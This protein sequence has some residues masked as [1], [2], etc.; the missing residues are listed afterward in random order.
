MI[1]PN[2]HI[3]MKLI[4]HEM[5]KYF[6]SFFA[7]IDF[8]V[9][10]PCC[11]LLIGRADARYYVLEEIYE[12]E[13]TVEALAH[14]IKEIENKWQVGNIRRWVAGWGDSV[15]WAMELQKYGIS[16]QMVEEKD[17]TL[18]IQTVQYLLTNN[19]YDGD[20]QLKVSPSCG[21][22]IR[23]FG[24]YQWK[25][26]SDGK[27]RPGDKPLDQDN[28]AMDAMRYALNSER[29]DQPQ[30]QY[31]MRK[32]VKKPIYVPQHSVTGY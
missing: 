11:Y 30:R 16:T 15:H 32:K 12:P 9:S 27:V 26:Q 8:G 3:T 23:E 20:P 1:D 5:A 4:N 7:G 18:G 13:L 24:L 25:T 2:K 22:T 17:I 28:H 10:D 21:N 14:R 6:S 29:A 19:L 31:M